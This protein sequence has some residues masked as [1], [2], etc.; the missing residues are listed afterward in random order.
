MKPPVKKKNYQAPTLSETSRKIKEKLGFVVKDDGKPI[1]TDDLAGSSAEKKLSFIPM[2]EAFVE[3]TKLPGI[4]MGYLTLVAGWSD[5]GKSTLVNE[6][7][8]SCVNNGILPVYFDT[9]GNFD[10]QFAIDCGLKATPIYREKVNEDTGELYQALVDWDTDLIYFDKDKLLLQWGK[11]DYKQNKETSKMRSQAVIEDIAMAINWFLDLQHE[12]EITQPLCFIWDSIG[13]ISS[14]A[15]ISG[16]KNNM[17]DAGALSSA[18]TD[19]ISGRIPGS[20]KVSKKYTNT[21]FCVNKVW[22]DSMNSMGGVPS[23]ELKGGKTFFYAA[24]LI[25]HLGGIAKA[26]TKKLNATAKGRTYRY[27]IVTKIRVTKNQLPSP[28]N[29]TYEG[30]M[31]CVHNGLLSPDRLDEYKR[32]NVKEILKRLEEI[33]ADSGDNVEINEAD[34]DFTEKDEIG[35]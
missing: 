11:W 35:D 10:Y 6:L 8:A 12:G 20:R 27:G 15:S 25:L 7:I 4:P 26:A 30:E 18:F 13:T 3:A 31:A 14:Y 24:R 17:Y 34:I 32:N 29:I 21:M 28:Y 9:E 16:V 19:I 33:A 2:S 5:T 1:T 23:I 22:N